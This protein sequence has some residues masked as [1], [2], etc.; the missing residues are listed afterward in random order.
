MSPFSLVFI[1]VQ[2]ICA[3]KTCLKKVTGWMRTLKILTLFIFIQVTILKPFYEI[4][5]C[6]IGKYNLFNYMV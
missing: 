2:H 6:I 5:V 4:T 1:P 3:Q